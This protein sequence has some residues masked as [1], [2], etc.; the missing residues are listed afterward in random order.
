VRGDG[1]A[2]LHRLAMPADQTSAHQLAGAERV[3]Q[4]LGPSTGGI[5]VHVAEL[6]RLLR[7]R[8]WQVEVAGPHG[9]MDGVGDQSADVDVPSSWHPRHLLR[10]R[11]QLR[12]LLIDEAAPS[13]VHVHG[14]KAAL[15]LLSIRRVPRPPVVL[16]VHN[17]VAGTQQGVTRRVLASIERSIVRRVDHV[18]VISPEI[19]QRVER[20]QP[21][22]RCHDILPVSPRREPTLSVAEVRASYG[23][24]ADAPL[25]VIVARHHTQKDLPMF[26][27]SMALVGQQ[28]PDVR[29]VM[30]GDGPQ[31]AAV[32]AV[33]HRLGLDDVVV[34]AGHR[35]NPIDEMRAADVVALSSIWEGSPLAIAECLSIGAPL[36]TTSVGTVTRHLVDG[37]SARIVD[38]GDAVGFA[39][40]LTDLLRSP[41]RRAEIG[42]AGRAVAER[43]FDPDTLTDAVE[44]VY[45]TATLTRAA[46]R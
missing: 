42:A 16:T 6:T 36:V 31:R 9:V 1:A 37:E 19:G 26:L 4:L 11:G 8:G 18:I 34:I 14:L 35:P 27:A 32:E 7:D 41:D 44:M 28:V 45:R 38:V 21:A 13:V 10:A 24:A 3:L 33:R 40:A 23:I 43:T 20:L 12:P 30:V 5:R 46:S 22:D 29:A 17:L 15:V 2:V 25:V 39:A